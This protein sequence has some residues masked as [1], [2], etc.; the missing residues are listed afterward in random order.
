MPTLDT[1]CCGAWGNK[2][3]SE[4][5]MDLPWKPT[6]A[7]SRSSKLQWRKCYAY[8]IPNDSLRPT[9]S[10]CNSQIIGN[11]N[12]LTLNDF[13]CEKRMPNKY[14]NHKSRCLALKMSP[15]LSVQYTYFHYHFGP[16]NLLLI[17]YV[18]RRSQFYLES[19]LVTTLATKHRYTRNLPEGMGIIQRV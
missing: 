9:C 17:L 8:V 15:R 18:K 16:V 6:G 10:Y 7:Q 19:T 3:Y 12:L 14:Q 5:T 4:L 13:V 11:T 2:H 1:V